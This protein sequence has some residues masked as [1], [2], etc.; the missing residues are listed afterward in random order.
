MFRRQRSCERAVLFRKMLNTD[1]AVMPLLPDFIGDVQHIGYGPATLL[2]LYPPSTCVL[3][4]LRLYVDDARLIPSSS[5]RKRAPN[6]NK[7]AAS[8]TD[9]Q[10]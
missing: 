6:A 2:A 10:P 5:Y 9:S 7:A 8:N 3:N 1:K 4:S